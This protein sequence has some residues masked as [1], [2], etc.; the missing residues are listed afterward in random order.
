[1]EKEKS[2]KH[3]IDLSINYGYYLELGEYKKTNYYAKKILEFNNTIK[4]DP[5][6]ELVN[7]LK[8]LLYHNNNAVRLETCVILLDY[9]KNES[10]EVLNEIASCKKSLVSFSAKMILQELKKNNK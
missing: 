3:F 10:I 2:I 4:A 8:K 6:H 1:M 9:Y 7:D 5:N